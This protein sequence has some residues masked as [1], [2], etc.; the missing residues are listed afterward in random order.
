MP[1]TRSG[2][3]TTRVA[4]V[5]VP[6]DPG[7]AKRA[8]QVT[9]IIVR[10][11]GVEAKRVEHIGSTAIPGMAAK[12]VI[13]VQ[14]SVRDLDA[15][16]PVLAESLPEYGFVRAVP[17]YDHVP[18]GRNDPPEMW[19]KRVWI[20]RRHRDGDINLH[21]RVV[22]SPGERL[23]LL[24]RDWFRAHPGAIAAYAE[25]KHRLAGAVLDVATYSD[26]KDPVVDLLMVTAEQWATATDWQP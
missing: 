17:E 15:V 19:R 8:D 3:A 2:S 1:E 9:S 26:V 16:T 5:V 7:W 14:L 13:D 20:R 10:A 12:D 11:V 25:F 21:V 18:A 6:Y 4:P 22:G 24:F 23:A